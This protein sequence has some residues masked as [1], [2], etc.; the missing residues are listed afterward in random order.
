MCGPKSPH[1]RRFARAAS[2]GIGVEL[3]KFESD[4][5][6]ECSFSYNKEDH[7]EE[8]A[9]YPG[10]RI[11]PKVDK[12]KI[13]GPLCGCDAPRVNG[14]CPQ[15]ARVY[16]QTCITSWFL[17]AEAYLDFTMSC[18]DRKF[19]AVPNATLQNLE[20]SI[21]LSYTIKDSSPD[22]TFSCN[23]VDPYSKP[24]LKLNQCSFDKQTRACS[25][26]SDVLAKLE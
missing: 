10:M 4:T 8:G 24:P 12:K 20:W 16:K 25:T 17:S 11:T 22:G 23:M 7:R 1:P 21:D 26:S 6:L 9:R 3:E 19:Q 15:S 2:K 18:Q 14:T 5:E 13:Q